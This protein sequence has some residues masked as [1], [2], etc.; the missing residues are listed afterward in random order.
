MLL[1]FDSIST[2]GSTKVGFCMTGVWRVVIS[3]RRTPTGW[4]DSDKPQS[5]KPDSI[6]TETRSTSAGS[7]P[8][9]SNAPSPHAT[10]LTRPHS[11]KATQPCTTA[12]YFP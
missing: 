5:D 3:W 6:A 7:Y 10:C 8:F 1:Y 11:A 12:P 2:R 4:I 9:R